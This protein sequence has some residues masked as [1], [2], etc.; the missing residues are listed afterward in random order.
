MKE[1]VVLKLPEVMRSALRKPLGLLLKDVVALLEYLGDKTPTRLVSVGDV[2]T[3]NLL[4]A[5]KKPDIVVV[6]SIAMRS[7]VAKGVRERIEGFEA[8]EIKV[9][10]PAGTITPELRKALEDT[11]LPV[12]IVVDGEEDLATL[13]AV[14]SSPLGSVVVYGQPGEGLVAIEVTAEKREEF[15]KFLE[16]FEKLVPKSTTT[17]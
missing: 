1:D 17:Q 6:D 12:K 7:P 16:R 5:G 4:A 2:V 11:Q 10:N 3:S 14:I 15:L 9:K 13:P 8:R